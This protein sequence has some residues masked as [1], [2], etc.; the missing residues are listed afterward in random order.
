MWGAVGL[1]L[2]GYDSGAQ[3]TETGRAELVA[4]GAVVAVVADDR[5]VEQT[6]LKV[7]ATLVSTDIVND[8]RSYR[9]RVRLPN[10]DTDMRQ[11]GSQLPCHD[12]TR[13]VVFGVV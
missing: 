12:V 3:W 5:P 6:V 11:A 1:V 10:D 9:I 7:R 4:A 13:P 8:Q 2:S